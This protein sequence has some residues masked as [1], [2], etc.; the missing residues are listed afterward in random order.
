[1]I[2]E[3]QKNIYNIMASTNANWLIFYFKRIP[4]IGRILPDNIYGNQSIKKILAVIGTILRIFGNVLKKALFIFLFLFL[5]VFLIEKDH[6]LRYDSYLHVFLMINLIGSF[7]TSSIFDS[8]RN[9]FICIHLMHMNAKSYIVS[10]VLLQQFADFFY[11][12][13][14][15][16]FFTI[17][18]GGTLLH[19]LLLTILLSIFSLFGETFFLLIY[20][21]TKR[22]LNR[23]ITYSVFI[24]VLCLSATYIPVFLH[25]PLILNGLLF[26]PAFLSI[27][28][29]L[30]LYCIYIILKYNRYFEI[31]SNTLKASN[32]STDINQVI[33]EAK[34]SDVAVREKE[35]TDSDLKSDQFDNKNGFAYLN[36]IFFQRHKRL[37]VKPII[38]R[39]ILIAIVFIAALLVVHRFP[40][41]INSTSNPSKI[42]PIFVFI[43]YFASIGER[44][45]RAMFYNCDISLLRYSFYRNKYA[46]LSNFK[47]RLF[48]IAELNSIIAIAISIAVATL[49]HIFKLNWPALDM[50]SFIISILFL[51]LFF[52]VHHLFLYYVF[53]PYTTEL[54]MKNPFFN[55]INTGVY[56][57]CYFCTNIKS[58]PSYFSLIV[59]ISTFI[60]IVIALILVYKYA[61]KTFRVK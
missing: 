24:A 18:M 52:S 5:P 13:P 25:R 15:M 54:G 29:V 44:V 2:I 51:S 36:A 40:D 9:K 10:T 8:D 47:V 50:L 17:R 23:K 4:I 14:V 7:L 42:L 32:F 38:I 11:F 43:I 45:C 28:L 33:A 34:F 31:A 27:M 61:P 39:L 35:F 48:R 12:L 22:I 19:G 1:M 41:I 21:K 49:V 37:L 6:T 16:L 26:H 3:T 55:I 56:I 30:Y 46:I 60:Y 20:S 58:P 57:L 53:Q 59:L